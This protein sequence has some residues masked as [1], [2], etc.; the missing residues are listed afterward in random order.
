MKL[1]KIRS[2]VFD[3]GVRSFKRSCNRPKDRLSQRA[4]K[5]RKVVDWQHHG[6]LMQ[7]PR[8]LM[9][10]ERGDAQARARRSARCLSWR[11]RKCPRGGGPGA[12]A[13]CRWGCVQTRWGLPRAPRAHGCRCCPAA[14]HPSRR[15][16]I[17]HIWRPTTQGFS[18]ATQVA[19]KSEIVNVQQI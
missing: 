12:D 10:R 5:G 11:C 8:A 18:R 15:T 13:A 2:I 14:A 9:G 6:C 19:E 4:C 3:E 7:Q 1:L 17:C 16:R